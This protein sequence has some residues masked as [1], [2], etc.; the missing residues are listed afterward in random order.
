M[1]GISLSFFLMLF[2]NLSIAQELKEKEF[3]NKMT[4]AIGHAH[5]TEWINS[6]TGERETKVLPAWALDYDYLF[7]NKW[8]LGLHADV[9]VESFEV[10]TFESKTIDRDYPLAVGLI[11]SR[12]IGEHFAFQ[13][14][15]GVEYA[16]QESFALLRL[17]LDYG[18]EVRGDFEV[19]VICSYDYKIRGYQTFLIGLGVGKFW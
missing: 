3:R 7:N 17:G 4:L 12:K 6:T 10:E 13:I 11:A 19:N 2:F 18:W 9:I 16:A 5:P 1:K 14:G 15:P 8:S